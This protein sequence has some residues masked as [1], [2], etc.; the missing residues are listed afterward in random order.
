M[1]SACGA[2]DARRPE[3]AA[4]TPDA[5]VVRIEGVE[6]LVPEEA[7]ERLSGEIAEFV[8]EGMA[9]AVPADAGSVGAPSTAI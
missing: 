5:R 2:N 8:A 7:P 3:L 6:R 1:V 9:P 4:G